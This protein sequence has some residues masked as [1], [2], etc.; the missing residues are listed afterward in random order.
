MKKI[1]NDFFILGLAVLLI[2]EMFFA[3]GI[4]SVHLAGDKLYET[5]KAGLFNAKAVDAPGQGPVHD[6]V[7]LLR[8]PRLLLAACAGASLAVCGV[9]MQSIVK[10]PLADPYVLGVS[11]GAS[12]GATV[13]IFLGVGLSFGNNFIGVCSFIGALGVS[14]LVL[15][16]ANIG[17][18]ANSVKLLLAGMALNTACSAIAS[19]VVYFANDKNG[20]QTV[21]FWLMG[22][23]AGA[24]WNELGII[25]GI[26]LFG[27]LF[28]WSQSRILDMML[29]GDQTAITLGTDL[30]KYRQVYLMLSSLMV[31]FIVY[32]SG[33]IG[34]VGLIV[35]HIVRL[36]A[37]TNHNYLVPLS[38]LA[39]ALLLVLADALCRTMIPRTEIPVG[40]LISLIGAPGFVWLIAKKSYGFGGGGS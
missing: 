37:G 23:F 5:V 22:S 19:F 9:V 33:M 1:R 6:I 13:S 34:F 35:P 18:T 3:L 39:G 2:V 24:D 17:S 12:L 31:G 36:F 20:I 14:M 11:S 16:I 40:I 10:N 32:A 30:R 21:L 28:F 29:F 15:I 26:T 27:I 7:W 4:G 38:A 8:M 25:V